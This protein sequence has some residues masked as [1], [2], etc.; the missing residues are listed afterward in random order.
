MDIGPH[1]S[2]A[3]G[4]YP[5]TVSN[6]FAR[7]I[8]RTY[9][10]EITRL[11]T[12]GRQPPASSHIV[13]C[14]TCIAQALCSRQVFYHTR[15]CFARLFLKKIKLFCEGFLT[16]CRQ[17]PAAVPRGVL[18]PYDTIN[19]VPAQEGKAQFPQKTCLTF[20]GHHKKP[21]FMPAPAKSV[22]ARAGMGQPSCTKRQR[23]RS[24]SC[25]R[26][27]EVS[28]ATQPRRCLRQNQPRRSWG[29]GLSFA[30][31]LR[32]P[33]QKQGT[34]TRRGRGDSNPLP[35]PLA[36]RSAPQKEKETFIETIIQRLPLTIPCTPRQPLPL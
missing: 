32:R 12:A 28:L 6:S 31:A 11:G 13:A 2:P 26:N 21:V 25:G 18:P 4:T 17:S 3:A 33:Q 22:P 10:A 7:F 8:D 30:R 27:G 14:T 29:S 20:G 36:Q 35:G 15:T 34:A 5:F 23:H 9:S 24:A 16:L 1:R 19:C